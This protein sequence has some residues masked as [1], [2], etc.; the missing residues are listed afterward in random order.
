MRGLLPKSDGIIEALHRIPLLHKFIRAN[1]PI[2]KGNRMESPEAF[3]ISDEPQSNLRQTDAFGHIH[4]SNTLLSLLENIDSKRPFIIGLFGKWGVGKTTI[5]NELRYSIDKLS[6]EKPRKLQHSYHFV[7]LDVWEFSAG[8]FRREFLLSLASHFN[9]REKIE[10]K[11]NT[12][13]TIKTKEPPEINV[14]KFKDIGLQL[15]II[16]AFWALSF[17]AIIGLNDLLNTPPELPTVTALILA[18]T[19]RV[20]TIG[21]ENIRD[22]FAFQNRTIQ[23]DPIIHPDQFRQEFRYIMRDEARITHK[24]DR[25]VI[26]LD[27]LDRVREE[28]AIQ[29]LGAVKT[30]LKEERCV[31]ILP[32]DDKGLK[33]HIISMRSGNSSGTR[34]SERQ[35]NEYLRKFFHTTLTIRDILIDDL[36]TFVSDKV[37]ELK[38][39]DFPNINSSILESLDLEN[40]KVKNQQEIS[41]VLQIALSK[42]PRR[43]IQIVNKL[44]T[45][46]LLISERANDS[47]SLIPILL[48]NLGFLTKLTVIEE[49]WPEFYALIT[50]YPD[51]MRSLRSYFRT[52]DKQ[53]IPGLLSSQVSDSQSQIAQEWNSGLQDF[54]RRTA[55]IH[56]DNVSEF[57]HFKQRPSVSRI[58]NYFAFVDSSRSRDFDS[59]EQ[60]IDDEMTDIGVAL[61]ELIK[62]LKN[63]HDLNNQILSANIMSCICLLHTRLRDEDETLL[64]KAADVVSE[65]LSKDQYKDHLIDI[66]LENLIRT[67]EYSTLPEYVE[68]IISNIISKIDLSELEDQSQFI[69]R[70]IAENHT[71][72]TRQ[73][74][75]DIRSRL[76]R[77]SDNPSLQPLLTEY[78]ENILQ[79]GDEKMIKWGIPRKFFDYRISRIQDYDSE[80][81]NDLSLLLGFIPCWRSLEREALFSALI[82]NL[83]HR[84][85][86]FTPRNEFAINAFAK[87]EPNYLPESLHDQFVS[88][89]SDLYATIQDLGRK[90]LV[91]NTFVRYIPD[92]SETIQGPYI[93]RLIDT[94]NA[95]QPKEIATLIDAIRPSFVHLSR[96]DDVYE[97]LKRQATTHFTNRELRISYFRLSESTGQPEEISELTNHAWRHQL[98][99]GISA[100]GEAKEHLRYPKFRELLLRLLDTT[101]HLPPQQFN[102]ALMAIVTHKERFTKA[103]LKTLIEEL[104]NDWFTKNVPEAYRAAKDF[105][106]E[107]RDKSQDHYSYFH[108]QLLATLESISVNDIVNQ[109]PLQI[110]V[111]TIISDF[112]LLSK[113]NKGKFVDLSVNITTYGKPPQIRSYGYSILHQ[114]AGFDFDKFRITDE[115]MDDLS[116]ETDDNLKQKI[117]ETLLGYEPDMS[118]E[119]ISN[120]H[121]IFKDKPDDHV[122]HAYH[123]A[124]FES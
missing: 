87:I 101:D 88:S 53:S 23:I 105:W 57:I 91:T 7:G 79:T 1:W 35:A 38:I 43:I 114:I 72:L 122:L 85:P 119:Q 77:Y 86:Q 41:A 63:Q 56:S 90:Q 10:K 109:P 103:F 24:N 9:C 124:F 123:D 30:F 60:I 50:V 120:L 29:V 113:S 34:M 78:A 97:A 93:A 40:V 28:M 5:I 17:L 61:D 82:G 115:L 107:I 102:R 32:C 66:G 51:L 110:I 16:L 83:D 45:N 47:E 81:Q 74:R 58:A 108:S 80:A 71:M 68:I 65:Y 44:S 2:P 54:L 22:I 117:L 15:I 12:T 46:Y 52:E 19:I 106:K 39:L 99:H 3:F 14:D 112:D 75:K 49:E 4:Y 55:F 31:Y 25:L 20:I 69:L 92:I 89:M 121:R 67:I 27:N 42:N 37:S 104:A 94:I 95:S 73:N 96:K 111:D 36:D 33:E 64:S 11:L 118:N 6:S 76:E 84:G 21:Q 62:D 59:V 116:Q 70:Q 100:L 48:N 98:D 26:I 18:I 8:N 13:S